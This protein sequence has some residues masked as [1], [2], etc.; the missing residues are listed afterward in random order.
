MSTD[1]LQSIAIIA[2]GFA[3]IIHALLH[4]WKR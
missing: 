1:L 3:Q 2:I 4:G